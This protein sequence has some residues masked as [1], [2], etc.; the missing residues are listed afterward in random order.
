VYNSIEAFKRRDSE[1][2]ISKIND[3]IYLRLE[4]FYEIFKT[5]VDRLTSQEIVNKK[6]QTMFKNVIEVM[7]SINRTRIAIYTFFKQSGIPLY[8]YIN[9]HIPNY[10]AR[11]RNAFVA[12]LNQLSAL[13]AQLEAAEAAL[14]ENAPQRGEIQRI[15]SEIQTILGTIREKQGKV[16]RDLRKQFGNRNSLFRKFYKK[17]G[18]GEISFP[19]S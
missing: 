18:F 8:G 7:N 12:Y 11:E 19:S 5:T 10:N 6:I 17:Y 1:N 2:I 13:F 16:P 15:A 4:E 9:S 3:L 14:P